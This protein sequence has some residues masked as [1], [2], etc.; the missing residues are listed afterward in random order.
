[1]G[2]GYNNRLGGKTGLDY[3][4]FGIIILSKAVRAMGLDGM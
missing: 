1:M 3:V 2:I 4:T